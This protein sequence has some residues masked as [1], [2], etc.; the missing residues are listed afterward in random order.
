[1]SDPC[2]ICKPVMPETHAGP[3][4]P[5]V[6]PGVVHRPECPTLPHLTGDQQRQLN[7]DLDA[8]ARCHRR[9]VALS[10]DVWLG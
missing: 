5:V 10:R 1:M 2:P 3:G 9:A 8:I 4:V 6:L 7:A